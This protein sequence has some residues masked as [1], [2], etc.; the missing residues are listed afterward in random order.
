MS[1][2]QIT[3]HS[4]LD[5]L[6]NRLTVDVPTGGKALA[7]LSRNGSYEIAR[8]DKQIAGCPVIEVG[9]KLRMPTAPIRKV[10]GLE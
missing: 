9:G 2:V 1:D 10:L 6:L 3:M 4:L 8:R 5:Q 7:D